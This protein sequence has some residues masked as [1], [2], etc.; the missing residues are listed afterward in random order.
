MNQDQKYQI[1]A[2]EFLAQVY[3]GRSVLTHAGLWIQFPYPTPAEAKPVEE[4]EIFTLVRDWLLQTGGMDL[5]PATSPDSPVSP[6]PFPM[7]P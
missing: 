6:G 5:K 4:E 7:R 2:K 1:A 3:S